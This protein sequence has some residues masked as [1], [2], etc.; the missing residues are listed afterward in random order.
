MR[1]VGKETKIEL[2]GPDREWQFRIL[3]PIFL[4][5]FRDGRLH[6]CI[7]RRGL[8]GPGRPAA[9]AAFPGR[10]GTRHCRH[11]ALRRPVKADAAGIGF[12]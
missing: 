8:A 5:G 9:R 4:T 11:R 3:S 6:P 12:L 7:G 1:W 2:P 10:H